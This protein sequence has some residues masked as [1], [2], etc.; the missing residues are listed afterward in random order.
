LF[1]IPGALPGK[2]NRRPLDPLVAPSPH[3]PAMCRMATGIPVAFKLFSTG[4]RPPE[5]ASC[6]LHH[7]DRAATCDGT[8]CH[9]R[10]RLGAGTIWWHGSPRFF[11][12]P[13]RSAYSSA[14]PGSRWAGWID[15]GASSAWYIASDTRSRT[16]ISPSCRE[17]LRP[18][19]KQVPYHVLPLRNCSTA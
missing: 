14:W 10:W 3:A 17:R 5:P 12:S 2:K 13:A 16:L 9:G 8:G 11:A 7:A 19:K 1:K 18:L 15:I 4:S 6:A